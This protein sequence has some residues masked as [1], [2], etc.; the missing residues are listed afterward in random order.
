MPNGGAICITSPSKWGLQ[1]CIACNPYYM[2][3]SA[4]QTHINPG[5]EGDVWYEVGEQEYDYF[6]IWL[7]P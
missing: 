1:T 5:A 6:L 7:A 3:F 4:P 2:T